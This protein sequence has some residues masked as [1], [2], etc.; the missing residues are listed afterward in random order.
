MA[1]QTP[2]SG[3]HQPV[4]TTAKGPATQYDEKLCRKSYML[5]RDFFAETL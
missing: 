1:E 3:R 4:S 5:M 2:D